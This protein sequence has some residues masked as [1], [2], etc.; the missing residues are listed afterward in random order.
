MLPHPL[1]A[2]L[3]GLIDYAG[4]FPPASLDLPTT[5]SHFRDYATSAEQWMLGRLIVPLPQL[6]ALSSLVDGFEAPA[7]P[8]WTVSLLLAADTPPADV[9]G[10]ARQFNDRYDA[11]GVAVVSVEF[12][13][14]DAAAVERFATDVPPWLERYVEIAW[15]EG[16]DAALSAVART[17]CYAKIRTGG[18]TPDRFP[19]SD[20]VA[21]F[22][23]GAIERQVPFKATAGLH[24]PLRNRYPLTDEPGGASARMHGFL[25]LLVATAV[26]Q[27]DPSVAADILCA[28]L[29][30]SSPAAFTMDD[31][32]LSWKDQRLSHDDLVTARAQGLRSVGSCSFQEPVED[33]R[34][35]GWWPK[36]EAGSP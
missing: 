31:S 19:P 13:A 35:M 21:S 20:T 8:A 15:G 7:R 10:V 28:I 1:R 12:P 2:G 14:A 9:S 29:D 6:G 30:E 33:L 16:G 24:H 5:L 22:V 4:L 3:A 25:N 11:R 36:P 32:G 17:G 26:A 27:R 34:R 18:I 23:R